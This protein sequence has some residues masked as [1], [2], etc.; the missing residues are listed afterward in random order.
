M[1]IKIELREKPRVFDVRV[2]KNSIGKVTSYVSYD[3][4]GDT[5][6]YEAVLYKTDNDKENM[7]LGWHA[8][9][10]LAAQQ[11]LEYEHGECKIDDV[12]K[13]KA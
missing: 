2:G 7:D 4:D 8:T 6:Q 3:D 5:E 12:K 11:V 10:R 1:S 9:L 13:R